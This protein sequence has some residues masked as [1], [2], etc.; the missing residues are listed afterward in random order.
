MK[1]FIALFAVLLL[2]SC[3]KQDVAVPEPEF[4]ALFA[5]WQMVQS[6]GG[7]NYQIETPETLGY[8]PY[9]ELTKKG[10][11]FYYHNDTLMRNDHFTFKKVNDIHSLTQSPYQLSFKNSGAYFFNVSNDSLYLYVDGNDLFD[12]IYV[13]SRN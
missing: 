8:T 3:K 9:L 12:Y 11:A 2:F 4:E 6:S 5:Q 13:K 7:D 1:N 10:E